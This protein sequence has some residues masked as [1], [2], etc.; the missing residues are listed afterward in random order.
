MPETEISNLKNEIARLN[1]IIEALLNH[2]EQ[3]RAENALLKTQHPPENSGYS[4]SEKK[5]APPN[6]SCSITENENGTTHDIYSITEKCNGITD[7]IYSVPE[8]GN[9]TNDNSSSVSEKGNGT[10][11]VGRPVSEKVEPSASNVYDISSKLRALDKGK[12]KRSGSKNS[13]KLLI[14]FHNGNGGSH[15]ELRKLTGLSRGGL[16][17]HI[18]SL[19]KRGLIVRNGWQQFMLTDAGRQMLT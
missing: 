2:N 14:H 17:K 8:K 9:G 12:V 3:L 1:R 18:M 13:A 19:T 6:S 16:A 15:S 11:N 5:N 7:D 10:T 4:V